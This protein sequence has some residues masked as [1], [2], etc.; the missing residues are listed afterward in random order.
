MTKYILIG[1]YIHKAEDGGEALFKEMLKD[2]QADK[3][4]KVLDCT[5]AEPRDL[6]EEKFQKDKIPF[7][8][9]LK[10]FEFE[11][12]EPSKFVEQVK[13]SDVIFLRGGDS[14]ELL[15]NSLN[16][17]G[18][19]A[20]G[21]SGKTVAGTSAGGDVLSKYFYNLDNPKLD[22]GLGLLDIKFIPH[23]RSDYNASNI[24]WDQALKELKN[25]K[26][27]LPVYVL[28]E[29]EFVVLRA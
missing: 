4:V 25:Y 9:F 12:A 7:L 16:K 8:K 13:S 5:W 17:I 24:D 2:F 6:W 23:W 15:I 26:E 1:G 20:E 21:L 18:N 11:L 10:N 14:T 27:D 29:G 19:L 28:K 3:T 22:E